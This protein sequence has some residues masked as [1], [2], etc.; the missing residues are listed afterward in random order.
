MKSIA[1]MAR[2]VRH[3]LDTQLEQVLEAEFPTRH[4]QFEAVAADMEIELESSTEDL[5][6]G[7]VLIFSQVVRLVYD[8]GKWS[9][10]DAIWAKESMVIEEVSV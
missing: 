10:E 3:D 1:E 8:D 9:A 7:A 5:A 4:S 6:E 2:R